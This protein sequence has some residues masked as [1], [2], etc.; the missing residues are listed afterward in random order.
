MNSVIFNKIIS[1]NTSFD[2]IYNDIKVGLKHLKI[3]KISTKRDILIKPNLCAIKGPETGATTDPKIVEAI[4]MYFKYDLN[5]SNIYIVESDGTQVQANIAFK[6]LGYKKLLKEYNVK[7]INLS[8]LQYKIKEFKNNAYLKKIRIPSIFED[9][10]YLISVPKIKTH[11]KCH[12]SGA[13]KNQYGCNPYLTV[14]QTP[15]TQ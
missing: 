3:S 9:N 6:V 1:I 10:P 12:I 8:N 2:D 13:L 11:T 14:I 5:L 15:G 4:I 7:F